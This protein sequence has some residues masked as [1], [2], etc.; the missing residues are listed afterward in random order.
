MTCVAGMT[1]QKH[2]TSPD[3]Q[4]KEL[5]QAIKPDVQTGLSRRAIVAIPVC[6]PVSLAPPAL[7]FLKLAGHFSLGPRRGLTIIS[8]W[9]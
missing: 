6:S 9:P 7:S 4:L 5:N 3:G 2:F 8:Y 1:K